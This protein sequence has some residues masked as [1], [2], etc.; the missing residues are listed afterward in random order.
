MTN[1]E[2]RTLYGGKN[3][4]PIFSKSTYSRLKDDNFTS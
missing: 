2:I 1:D 3:Y 4:F